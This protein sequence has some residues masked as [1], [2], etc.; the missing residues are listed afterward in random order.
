MTG[1]SGFFSLKRSQDD[2]N[3]LGHLVKRDRRLDHRLAQ[4]T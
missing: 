3:H 2:V 4:G 1:L